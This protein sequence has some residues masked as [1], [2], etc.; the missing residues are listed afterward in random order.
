MLSLDAIYP[1]EAAEN[2]YSSLI[3]LKPRAGE[4]RRRLGHRAFHFFEE[5]NEL[6]FRALVQRLQ[7]E[8]E[9]CIITAPTIIYLCYF[10][11]RCPSL[12]YFRV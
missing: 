5:A 1:P 9:C 2:R 11:C 6:P 10:Q 12:Y 4:P 8:I 7:G 3:N